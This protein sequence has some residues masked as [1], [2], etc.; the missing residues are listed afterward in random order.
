[1]RAILVKQ[2][3]IL[4]HRGCAVHCLLKV[5]MC[6]RWTN[7][8]HRRDVGRTL[9]LAPVHGLILQSVLFLDVFQLIRYSAAHCCSHT[10]LHT[11][12][13]I[14]LFQGLAHLVGRWKVC[15]DCCRGADTDSIGL[16]RF[17]LPFVADFLRS[18]NCGTTFVHRH[19]V[20]IRHSVPAIPS[21][22]SLRVA[23]CE[24][25][26][27]QPRIHAG[28]LGT[29]NQLGQHLCMSRFI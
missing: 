13:H 2:I 14:C 7:E 4:L 11:N 12:L 16:L 29:L 17:V 22:Q 6:L 15:C 10:C 8:A 24:H 18:E 1:M 20:T 3:M 23:N 27:L 5:W 25:R 19:M 26:L 9:S 21:D 28:P